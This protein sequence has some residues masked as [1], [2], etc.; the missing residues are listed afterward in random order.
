MS[1]IAHDGT[2]A[3][4]RGAQYGLVIRDIG[5]AFVAALIMCH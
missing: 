5:K 2:R 3:Q 4:A 1:T